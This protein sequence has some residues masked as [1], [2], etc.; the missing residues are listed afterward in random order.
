[1][2]RRIDADADPHPEPG[3]GESVSKGFCKERPDL[4]LVRLLTHA[5]QKRAALRAQIEPDQ[6]AAGSLVGPL[7][8]F[9]QKA[10]A[11]KGAG[12]I[13][14]DGAGERSDNR[15]KRALGV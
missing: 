11:R 12:R 5:G 15:L 10:R 8:R 9:D 14:D 13:N 6:L 2:R 7:R 3:R 4:G 1:L